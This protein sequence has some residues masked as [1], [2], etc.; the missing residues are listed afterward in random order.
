M[1]ADEKQLLKQILA[2]Q[3]VLFRQIEKIQEK[4]KGSMSMKGYGSVVS[5]LE[6][7]AS[8]VQEYL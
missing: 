3:V 1:S 4:M 5:D 2:N 6:R 7:E 8:K